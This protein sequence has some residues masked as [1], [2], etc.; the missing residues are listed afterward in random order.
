MDS[1]FSIVTAQFIGIQ[2]FV[3]A[4][5]VCVKKLYAIMCNIEED[6]NRKFYMQYYK[7]GQLESDLDTLKTEVT[8]LSQ[9]CLQIPTKS[10]FNDCVEVVLTDADADADADA[11]AKAEIRAE[12][13]FFVQYYKLCQLESEFDTLKGQV[14]ELKQ[15]CEQL[16]SQIATAHLVHSG[17]METCTIE[18]VCL[19]IP[20][21]PSFNDCVEVV[22][23]N[24]DADADAKA[25]ANAEVGLSIQEELGEKDEV[26]VQPIEP[27]GHDGNKQKEAYKYKYGLGFLMGSK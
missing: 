27:E 12:R 9:V 8:K 22:L 26:F 20:T 15:V 5:M 18:E 4:T 16:R 11:Y 23:T 14:T 6:K 21:K 2:L 17:S 3:G 24:T 19:Q 25:G 7:I 1:F 10:S 13:K